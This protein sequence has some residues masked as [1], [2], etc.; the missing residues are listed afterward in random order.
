MKEWLFSTIFLILCGTAFAAVQPV[1][2]QGAFSQG[3][4]LFSQVYSAANFTIKPMANG[5]YPVRTCT[6]QLYCSK[7]SYSKV[8][9]KP[10]GTRC[11][12]WKQLQGDCLVWKTRNICSGPALCYNPGGQATNQLALTNFYYS[13]DGS[14]WQVVPY[15]PLSLAASSLQF[16]VV[17][18]AVCSPTYALDKVITLI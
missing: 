12:Q 18:P 16:K 11:L 7:Y 13:T 8:C 9:I 6:Q 10:Q 1:T 3:T 17:I 15:K 2:F 5:A 14:S 4:T